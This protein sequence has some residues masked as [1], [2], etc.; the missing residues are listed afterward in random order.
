M[1]KLSPHHLDGKDP[2]ARVEDDLMKQR[3]VNIGKPV[4]MPP[5]AG[6]SPKHRAKGKAAKQARKKQRGR[7]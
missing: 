7:R 2:L 4:S 6:K 3:I 5:A 1:E